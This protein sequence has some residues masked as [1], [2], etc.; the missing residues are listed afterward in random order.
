MKA[1]KDVLELGARGPP[2]AVS[3][4]AQPA[5][6][7]VAGTSDQELDQGGSVQVT[8]PEVVDGPGERPLG[9]PRGVVQQGP[10]R[11][12]HG[13]AELAGAVAPVKAVAVAHDSYAP[14]LT[15]CADVERLSPMP[16]D[17]PQGCRA[18]VAEDRPLATGQDG[19]ERLVQ[20]VS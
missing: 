16:V 7:W 14:V 1:W 6:A 19:P 18:L 15:W 11:A 5:G 20:R 3:E 13:E 8:P 4:R 12:G 10:G 9:H 17:P 2:G